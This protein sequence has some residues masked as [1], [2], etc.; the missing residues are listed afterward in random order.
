[1]ELPSIV[2]KAGVAFGSGAHPTTAHVLALLG[3]LGPVHHAGRLL[4]VGCGAGLLAITAAKHYGFQVLATDIDAN[5]VS[6]TTANATAN[7]VADR[8]TVLRAD[9]LKHPRIQHEG[10]FNLILVNILCEVF[11][12]WLP[13]LR[14]LLAPGGHLVLS[15]VLR[16]QQQRVQDA[17][18]MSGLV[19]PTVY[20][21]GEWVALVTQQA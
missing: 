15:G 12:P 2:L 16:W 14:E 10:P 21:Q 6:Y 3:A 5:A 17:C 7:D 18:R 9:G 19:T 1:M 8:L 4:D 13:R 11:L 20:G